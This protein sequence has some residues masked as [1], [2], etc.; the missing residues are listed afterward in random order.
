M[1]LL[2]DINS[3][4][5]DLLEKHLEKTNGGTVLLLSTGAQPASLPPH[6]CCNYWDGGERW[7]S[8]SCRELLSCVHCSMQVAGSDDD[9]PEDDG[10]IDD[11]VKQHLQAQ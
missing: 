1:A 7:Q 11:Q 5:F 3:V 8:L 6:L 2:V 9:V 4:L 10:H